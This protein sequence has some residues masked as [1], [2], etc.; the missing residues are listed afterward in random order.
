VALED[1]EDLDVV[2]IHAEISRL[3]KVVGPESL[4]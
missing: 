2:T 4:V 1:D 3:R